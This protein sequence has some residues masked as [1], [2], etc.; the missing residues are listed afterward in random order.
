MDGKIV[1]SLGEWLS[2]GFITQ[3]Q[4]DTICEFEK[5]LRPSNNLHKSH[6]HWTTYNTIIEDE[7]KAYQ[8]KNIYDEHRR[9][10]KS[11]I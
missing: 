1:L 4:Y 3:D 10:H 8:L 6:D 5:S 11:E 7:R 9:T 2:R